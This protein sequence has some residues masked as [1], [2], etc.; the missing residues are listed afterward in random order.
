[1]WIIP[2]RKKRMPKTNTRAID[3]L[4]EAHK[5]LKKQGRTSDTSAG[6]AFALDLVRMLEKNEAGI[7]TIDDETYP[8]KPC[9]VRVSRTR[10]TLGDCELGLTSL[11]DGED[12]EYSVV[13]L[14]DE[15]NL[16][17]QTVPVRLSK[18]A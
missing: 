8:F 3:K 1:M 15:V 11:Q 4:L 2:E 14:V 6:Q 10:V 16:L 9:D 5:V 7:V 13:M 12:G 18:A 17:G